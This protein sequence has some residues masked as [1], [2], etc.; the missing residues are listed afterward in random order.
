[1]TIITPCA[2]P[3]NLPRIAESLAEAREQFDLSWFVVHDCR[4]GGPC[5]A[6]GE[7]FD[8][9]ETAMEVWHV[10]SAGGDVAGHAQA[11]RALDEIQRAAGTSADLIYR[12]DDDN[13]PVPGFFA[14]LR[15]LALGH[16]NV[17]LFLFAQLAAGRYDE[18]RWPTGVAFPV[19][20]VGM[21]DTAQ[22]VFRRELLGDL[23]FRADDYQADG[24]FVE[25]LYAK[26]GPDR[27]WFVNDPLTQYNAI[28]R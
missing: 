24:H 12:I 15:E 20:Q 4:S 9:W 18:A 26:A 6:M 13:L 7:H 17:D 14:R 22:F 25:A 21:M 27:T 19:P 11:N 16:P 5:D 28:R 10:A 2:R 8:G 23:R 1:L 3:E